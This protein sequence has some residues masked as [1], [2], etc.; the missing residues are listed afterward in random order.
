MSS[1]YNIISPSKH[2]ERR[3]KENKA[4]T[5]DQLTP[6]S[7]REQKIQDQEYQS[8]F[9]DQEKKIVAL[10]SQVKDING[11]LIK[12]LHYKPPVSPVETEKDP[13]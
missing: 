4:R 2:Q 12:V 7:P 6:L 8:K 3:E 10:T 11:F 13:E 5:K 9:E 1:E